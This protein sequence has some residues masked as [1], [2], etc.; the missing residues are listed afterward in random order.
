MPSL[1]AE[2]VLVRVEASGLNRADLMQRRG[3][4]PVPPGWTEDIL[5]MEF[6]GEVV[7]VGPRCH[8]RKVG[9]RVMGLVGGGGYAEY[10]AVHERATVVTPDGM[11]GPEAGAVPE[12]FMTAFDAVFSSW[13]KTSTTTN[14][15]R[16]SNKH[17]TLNTLYFCISLSLHILFARRHNNVSCFLP[18]V[19]F[20]R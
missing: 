14:Y 10:V 17:P 11:T 18:I 3:R 1:E 7:E 2:E 9:D 5:G 6:A 19:S 4:Y 16:A 13:K 12:V 20:Q 15:T 8:K